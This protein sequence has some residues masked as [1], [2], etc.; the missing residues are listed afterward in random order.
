MTLDEFQKLHDTCYGA[1]YG[2]SIQFHAKAKDVVPHLIE[3]ARLAT[4]QMMVHE[5]TQ[6]GQQIK[7]KIHMEIRAIEGV[8][9]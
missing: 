5:D 8:K 3:I 9:K 6:Q 2:G 4:E 1:G 7:H